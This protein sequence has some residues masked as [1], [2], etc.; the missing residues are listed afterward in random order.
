MS[1]EEDKKKE[2]IKT[3]IPKVALPTDPDFAQS[4]NDLILAY[5]VEDNEV[6]KSSELYKAT[7][8]L[9]KALYNMRKKSES[10]NK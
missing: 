8:R 5:A 10:E 2:K 1:A 6:V 9:I 4:F 3:N 7:S